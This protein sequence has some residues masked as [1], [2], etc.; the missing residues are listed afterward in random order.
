MSISVDASNTNKYKKTVGKL[1]KAPA[2]PAR[3]GSTP[4]GQ[5]HH[6]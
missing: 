3:E 5:Q 1:I 4:L 2:A 6:P